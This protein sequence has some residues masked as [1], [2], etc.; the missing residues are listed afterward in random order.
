[1]ISFW[2]SVVPPKIR[3]RGQFIQ[4]SDVDAERRGCQT[5][6]IST[7]VSEN[8][9][10]LPRSAKTNG[11][12]ALTV[13]FSLVFFGQAP[14]GDMTTPREISSLTRASAMN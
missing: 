8:V 2:I 12:T 3:K 11:F 4:G 14:I 13:E 7:L 6:A 10:A 5:W 1:M 9:G